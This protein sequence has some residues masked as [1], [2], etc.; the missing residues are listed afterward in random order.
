[1]CDID[2]IPALS[3]TNT[4][5]RVASLIWEELYSQYFIN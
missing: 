4:Q 5:N 1:M 2:D 3:V